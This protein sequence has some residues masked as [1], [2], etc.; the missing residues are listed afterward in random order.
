MGGNAVR[1]RKSAVLVLVLVIALTLIIAP[2]M[3]AQAAAVQPSGQ[4]FTVDGEGVSIG[5]YNI[6]G[7]NYV[8]LRGLAAA[9][10]GTP[11]QFSVWYMEGNN[12][13]TVATGAPY[14][15]GVPAEGGDQSATAALSNQILI[16]DGTVLNGLSVWNIG[17]NNYFKLAELETYLGYHLSYQTGTNTV[18]I[19]MG[20]DDEPPPEETD[21]PETTAPEMATALPLN[22][23][24]SYLDVLRKLSEGAENGGRGFVTDAAEGEAPFNAAGGSDYSGTN[25]QVA[26]IDEGDLVK[27]DGEYLYIL[28]GTQD[29]T[30]VKADGASSRVVSHTLVGYA[31]ST[32]GDSGAYAARTVS[33]SPRELFISGGRLIVLSDDS[34][35]REYEDA[36]GWHWDSDEYTCVDIYDVSDPAAPA[37]VASLGQD[38]GL[39]GSRELEGHVYL[40]TRY[41]V[42]DY[43]AVDPA[44]YV[45]RLYAEGAG[46]A[47]AA[48]CIYLGSGGSE[49]VV[50]GDYDVASGTLKS[51]LSV[52]G[53]GGEVY[54]S[55]SDLYVLGSRWE[56]R[57]SEKDLESVYTVTEYVEGVV[58]DICRFDLRGGGL[59]LAARGCVPGAIDSQFSADQY[60]ENLRIVTTAEESRYKTYVDET[61]HF[62]NYVWEDSESTTGLY[63]L[64]AGLNEVSSVTGL[65]PGEYVYSVRFDGETVYFCTY[66]SV[67]PLFAV[68]LSDPA[69]PKVLS[70]L[71]LTGFS[72]YLHAWTDGKLFG[73]GLETDEDTGRSEGL[74]LVMFDTSDPRN[75]RVENSFLLDADSSE[76][77]YD[78]RAFFIDGGKNVIGFVGDGDYYLFSYAAGTGFTRLAHITFDAWEHTVRGLWIG[79]QAY[80]IGSGMIAIMDMNDWHMSG[81]LN[82]GA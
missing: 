62:V 4:R 80:I 79:D 24:G 65:A 40:A 60:G 53:S 50:V 6:D 46:R 10:N 59:S 27:T 31:D 82:I 20:A 11:K 35:Y 36:G 54:M 61:Y 39:L 52:L 30:I 64:D 71:K 37:L 73:F 5:A 14:V 9:L 78:H 49:Y 7:Y 32:D 76:A 23:A 68:D 51:A 12:T 2:V 57:E 47:M 75:V 8:Q 13:V 63:V 29:L 34:A 41:W 72:E 22:A 55:G 15:G 48:D 26:G 56:S 25:V 21:A 42:Y 58:T 66:R 43:D 44:T 3:R 74:K 38:G 18:S 77:L 45:P 1:S 67:D 81:T 69:A 17:G 28:N 70:A 16:I 19:S 33:K